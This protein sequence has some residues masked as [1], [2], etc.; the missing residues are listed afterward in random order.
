MDLMSDRCR[1]LRIVMLFLGISFFFSACDCSADTVSP[2]EQ[3]C[4][5]NDD[6]PGD[7]E[8]EGGYCSGEPNAIDGPD[9]GGDTDPSTTDDAGDE[10]DNTGEPTDAG[11]LPDDAGD[12]PDDGGGLD[13]DVDF[14]PE[15]PDPVTCE[16]QGVEC[17]TAPNGCGGTTDCGGCAAGEICDTEESRGTCVETECTSDASCDAEGIECGSI[18]DGCGGSIHCGSCADGEVCGSGDDR[19]QCIEQGCTPITC[20]DANAE[21]GIVADGCGGF[22]D[23]GGCDGGQVCGTGDERGECTDLACTPMDCDD[24]SPGDCGPHPDG[25]GDTVDCGPCPGG[26]VCGTGPF[27]G[28]CV[29]PSCTPLTCD[30]YDDVNCG[31]V[32]DGCGGVTDNCGTCEDPE[33]CGGG[34]LPNV[35]GAEPQDGCDGLCEDQAIC[36]A[37]EATTLTGTV[38]A[39]NGDLPIPN[40][41]VY[42]PNVP[43]DDLPPIEPATQCIQCE[44]E[45]LGDPLV[46]TITEYDGTFE[47]RHVPAGVDFPLVIKIGQWRRVVT[48]SA[49]DACETHALDNEQTRLPRTQEEGSEH[50]NIPLTAVSTGTVDAIECVLHKLG[51]EE[52]EFTRHSQD[53]R[54]H[55]YRANGGV[56]DQELGDICDGNVECTCFFFTC[57]CTCNINKCTDR[58]PDSCGSG[59]SGDLMRE[60]LSH[61]LYS[62]QDVL[63]SYDMVVMDCEANDHSSDRSNADLERIRNYVNGGGR[64]FASHYAYDWLHNTDEL[65][66]TAIWGGGED[67]ANQSLAFVD[68]TFPGGSTFW[69]W[70]QLVDAD[71]DTAGPNGEPQIEI[72]DP[73]T[74][75]VDV[76]EGL[77]TR[78]VHTEAGAP[79]HVNRDSIQQ[80]TFQT[81]VFADE[82][83]QCGQV[84]YS[85]F[86]VT[87]V[88]NAAGP[89]FPN[90]CGGSELSPQEKVLA[91]MLFDLAACVSEDGEPPPPECTPRTCDDAGAEC[92]MI[93]DGCGETLDCGDC[94]EG[95][96]CGAGG[97][98]NICGGGCEPL[99]CDDHGADCGTVS[100]GCG[101]TIDCGDCPD[102][103][104]CGGGGSPNL[105]GCTPMTCDDHGAE[106]GT[107]DDGCGETID[108]GDCPE[109]TTCG[110]GGVPNIC[111]GDCQPLTCDDH[112]VECGTVDDGCGGTL[113]CG[114]CPEPLFCGGGGEANICGCS[115][116]S[117]D[118]HGAECGL[119][120]NGC[121]D[122]LDCG[123]CPDGM[124]CDELQCVPTACLPVGATCTD[125][126]QCCSEICAVMEGDE[127]ECIDG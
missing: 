78:W 46:G 10:P 28:E 30:D 83:E 68:D 25:C 67:F 48:I 76:D 116:L 35:C 118:D 51:V 54:I 120:S 70:L 84:A 63:D 113:D 114:D 14:D 52:S 66:Q 19:G 56:V 121:G 38:T 2:A 17:G 117:C 32:S 13:G 57:D 71:H 44:D 112:G 11:D 42:V 104:D 43:I 73:R 127:G 97:E 100:D 62:D 115:P 86:H 123:P 106:C 21:C 91:Y 7:Q 77:A 95:T 53:G 6:C 59:S 89:V 79:G 45:E 5:S 64:L 119:V 102:G 55:L 98:P 75:V 34:S 18:P 124:E 40:A 103:M 125:G 50:D 81:P 126:D 108:C 8:C 23:C 110:G 15:C 36:A 1:Y 69:D 99:S 122:I 101:G 58:H 85:A 65:E 9:A 41:V 4:T 37:G 24:H 39:P 22:I 33:I 72:T 88:N 82:S 60:N 109:G 107:V 26:E 47:L 61:H 90:Y 92:G 111:G 49:K 27:L 16:E 29:E 96:A 93:A 31:P 12:D 80:Y 105:C 20:T 3:S 94:P 87:N 74:Y